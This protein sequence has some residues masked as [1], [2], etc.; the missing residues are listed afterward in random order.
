MAIDNGDELLAVI[1]APDHVRGVLWGHIHQ[2][3]D[4]A[5][6]GIPYMATPST[7]VQFAPGSTD[8][9]VDNVPPG[10]RLLELRVDGMIDSEIVR[11]LHM[12]Q[13]VDLASAGY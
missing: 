7:C 1:D 6:N 12:P 13:G 9:Q 8:F 3:F 5:R 11:L 10:C 2:E 4:R